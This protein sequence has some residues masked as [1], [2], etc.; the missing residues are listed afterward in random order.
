MFRRKKRGFLRLLSG[1]ILVLY[2]C[3]V[4]FKGENIWYAS[5]LFLEIV[6]IISGIALLRET[7]ITKEDFWKKK[8]VD[9]FIG[10]FLIF[11]GLFPLGMDYKMFKF[12]PFAIEF[13]LNQFVLPSIIF[14]FGL[15]LIVESALLFSNVY[16]RE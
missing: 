2:G 12:F 8:I 7:I 10:I 9:A 14:V 16:Y 4:L 11:F 6:L 3:L 13:K 15:Y 5:N 1:V